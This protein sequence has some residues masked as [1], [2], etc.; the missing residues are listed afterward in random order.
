MPSKMSIADPLPGTAEQLQVSHLSS[1][2]WTVFAA[3]FW[4]L[5]CFGREQKHFIKKANRATP[6]LTEVDLRCLG[7]EIL[8]AVYENDFYCFF[9]HCPETRMAQTWTRHHFHQM[10]KKSAKEERTRKNRSRKRGRKR[11]RETKE[12]REKSEKAR[13]DMTRDLMQDS[14]LC[15]PPSGQEL[16]NDQS[17]LPLQ[18]HDPPYRCRT[19]STHMPPTPPTH[20]HSCATPCPADMPN[21]PTPPPSTDVLAPP[22]PPPLQQ[23]GSE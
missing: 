13:T 4:T 6:L 22:P 11:G 21:A 8:P 5:A 17:Q 16:S 15:M 23:H 1:L 9:T 10:S 20:T 7:E 19:L 2:T 18:T 14:F 3:M 12:K